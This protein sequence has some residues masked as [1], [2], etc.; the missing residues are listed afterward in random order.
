MNNLNIETL[1]QTEELEKA[2]EIKKKAYELYN[3]FNKYFSF[4]ADDYKDG[5]FRIWNDSHNAAYIAVKENGFV[6]QG[7]FLHE[8]YDV[9]INP[10][11]L[12]SYI[13]N[14]YRGVEHFSS[15]V[16]SAKEKKLKKESEK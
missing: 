7:R 6:Y 5:R 3:D 11:S 16:F 13:K 4:N 9:E 12:F 1:E 8:S 10:A 2:I 15:S 14:K